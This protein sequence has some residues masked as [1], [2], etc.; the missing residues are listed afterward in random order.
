MVS[1]YRAAIRLLDN[2]DVD[3]CGV[4]PERTPNGLSASLFSIGSTIEVSPFIGNCC[5]SSY[6]SA[7]E[8]V[9]FVT[10]VDN[11]LPCRPVWVLAV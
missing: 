10:N 8:L 5:C 6:Q 3:A 9:R 1:A 4:V 11:M 7:C 2:G